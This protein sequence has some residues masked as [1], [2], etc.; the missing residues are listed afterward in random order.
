MLS[1]QLVVSKYAIPRD[2]RVVS[3]VAAYLARE[4]TGEA[5]PQKSHLAQVGST[6]V[7]VG[8]C[9]FVGSSLFSVQTER[10]RSHEL[11][12]KLVTT[13]STFEESLL[14]DS[15]AYAL[16]VK[17]NH[18]Q[19]D[20]IVKP[21]FLAPVINGMVIAKG[22]VEVCQ[23]TLNRQSITGDEGS[24]ELVMAIDSRHRQRRQVLNR[25]LL[26]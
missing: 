25:S 11:N 12:T 4:F 20:D 10:S 9:D 16:L 23:V 17:S 8:S 18:S 15:K 5:L 21:K 24:L 14:G 19:I 3:H 22:N 13:E 7:R 1:E 26:D 2:C 6:L